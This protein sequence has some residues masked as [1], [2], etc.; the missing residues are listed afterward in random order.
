MQL[1]TVPPYYHWSPGLHVNMNSLFEDQTKIKLRLPL[2]VSATINFAGMVIG[3]KGQ[4]LRHIEH[5]TGCTLF[6]RTL[7]EPHVLIIGPSQNQV[8][9][10]IN[11]IKDITLQYEQS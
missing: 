6:V 3:P 1:N 5:N 4:T 11:A 8:K 9:R 10:A 2:P 7:D